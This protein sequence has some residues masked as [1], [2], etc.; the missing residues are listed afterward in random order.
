[1]RERGRSESRERE[2]GVRVW[3]ERLRRVRVWGER[4]RSESVGRKVEE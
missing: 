4:F 2:G 3:G 1:M